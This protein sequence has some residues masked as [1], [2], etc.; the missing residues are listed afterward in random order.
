MLTPEQVKSIRKHTGLSQYEFAQSRGINPRTYQRYEKNGIVDE[1]KA[2][3]L[4]SSVPDY[5]EE[6]ND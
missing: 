5:K 4:L 6:S 2:K 1:L 3:G